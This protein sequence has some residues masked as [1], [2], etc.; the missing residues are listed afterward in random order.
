MSHQVKLGHVEA[1]IVKDAS[2]AQQGSRV[3]PAPH[4]PPQAQATKPLNS[5]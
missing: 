5:H 4:S 1:G 2:H 3:Y